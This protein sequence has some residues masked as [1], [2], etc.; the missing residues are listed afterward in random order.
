MPCAKIITMLAS[1]IADAISHLRNLN[2]I[3]MSLWH[4]APRPSKALKNTFHDSFVLSFGH[5]IILQNHMACPSCS[6][7]YKDQPAP[8]SSSTSF[9]P[10]SWIGSSPSKVMKYSKT[11]KKLCRVFKSWNWNSQP[12]PVSKSLWICLRVTKPGVTS[13]SQ[14]REYAACPK[15]R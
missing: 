15:D 14:R 9:A 3:C 5:I 11:C 1:E 7:S 12:A 6:H 10:E 8:K 13:L 4:F 2:W